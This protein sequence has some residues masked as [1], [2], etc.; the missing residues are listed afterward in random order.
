M[1]ESSPI[2]LRMKEVPSFECLVDAARNFPDLDPSATDAFL[3]LIFA[4]DELR[5]MMDEH[6][7]DHGITQGR[8]KVMLSLFQGLCPDAVASTTPAALADELGVT[9]A[10]MTGLL[11]SLER[12]GFVRR[13]PD[14]ADRRQMAVSLTPRGEAFMRR[15]LPTHFQLISGL[16]ADLTESERKTFVRLLGKLVARAATTRERRVAAP[17]RRPAA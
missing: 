10:T 4:S 5:A 9:R 7:A 17:A 14:S 2:R 8:F 15:F 16:A 13:E 3:N 1:P 11:D 6:F 12:D